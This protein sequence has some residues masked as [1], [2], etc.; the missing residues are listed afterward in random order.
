MKFFQNLKKWEVFK[1]K[2]IGN[3]KYE[4]NLKNLHAQKVF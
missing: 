4:N 3:Q 1:S 2:E